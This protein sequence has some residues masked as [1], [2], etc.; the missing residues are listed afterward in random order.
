MINQSFGSG[1]GSVRKEKKE[2]LKFLITV[3][4]PKSRIPNVLT[5]LLHRTFKNILQF[6]IEIGKEK[7]YVAS[8]L[9]VAAIAS[10]F[11]IV[12]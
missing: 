5:I 7:K 4:L 1:S 8:I 3:F 10:D 6:T 12:P 9:A 11:S 2:K